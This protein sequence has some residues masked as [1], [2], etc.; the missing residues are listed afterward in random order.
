MEI[1]CLRSTT[2]YLLLIMPDNDYES[3]LRTS[4]LE[5]KKELLKTFVEQTVDYAEQHIKQ[6]QEELS[7]VSQEDKDEIAKRQERLAKWNSYIEFQDHT[8][9]ELSGE[10]L[11][12]FIP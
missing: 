11:N 9:E 10:K 1:K 5:Y 7:L 2:F 3:W 4:P 12:R 6:R 8:L